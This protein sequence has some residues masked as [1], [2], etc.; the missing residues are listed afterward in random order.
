MGGGPTKRKEAKRRVPPPRHDGSGEGSPTG[1]EDGTDLCAVPQPI[2]FEA[3]PEVSISVGLP[4][5]L[6]PQ[7]LPL[8]V[9]GDQTIG[10]VLE[11]HATAMRH[12]IEEGYTM[13]GI[14]QSFEPIARRGILKLKGSRPGD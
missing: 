5:R 10:N 1:S 12:C 11:P 8:V 14:I 2:N 13:V 4:V 3:A 6:L 7:Y 9:A